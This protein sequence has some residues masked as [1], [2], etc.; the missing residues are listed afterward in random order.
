M[1]GGLLWDI[2]LP[3]P[4]YNGNGNGAPAA[5]AVGDLDGDGDADVLSASS[6]DDKIAW[7]ESDGGSPPSCPPLCGRRRR[8]PTWRGWTV[9]SFISTTSSR[10]W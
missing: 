2:P 4:G 5:P 6:R 8:R 7:Y 1:M 9:G 3:D 10:R